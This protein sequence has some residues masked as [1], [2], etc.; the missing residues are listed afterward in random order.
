LAP[1]PHP[2]PHPHRPLTYHA[3][4]PLSVCRLVNLNFGHCLYCSLNFVQLFIE[5]KNMF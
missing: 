5:I 1:H 4:L 3:Q 2:H